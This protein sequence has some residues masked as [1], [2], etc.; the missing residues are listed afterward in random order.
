MKHFKTYIKKIVT[1]FIAL[2]LI[3]A[4][5]ICLSH[6]DRVLVSYIDKQNTAYNDQI[7]VLNNPSDEPN[8][9][10]V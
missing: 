1:F 10:I 5:Q 3:F 9:S 2:F 7:P 8:I 4:P 6:S